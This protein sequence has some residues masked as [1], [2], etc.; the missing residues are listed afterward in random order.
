MGALDPTELLRTLGGAKVTVGLVPL[1]LLV[2][3]SPPS[4]IGH[5]R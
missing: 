2:P 3:Y 1:R 4:F 5:T